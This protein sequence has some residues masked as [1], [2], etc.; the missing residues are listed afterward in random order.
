MN[1]RLENCSPHYGFTHIICRR[2]QFRVEVG[3][4]LPP[5]LPK[6]FWVRHARLQIDATRAIEEILKPFDRNTKKKIIG[7]IEI[8]VNEEL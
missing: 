5:C 6:P 2:C 3:H 8:L 4:E 1:K 7:I